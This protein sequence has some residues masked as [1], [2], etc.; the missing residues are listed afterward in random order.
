MGNEDLHTE[1]RRRALRGCNVE[2]SMTAIE[3]REERFVGDRSWNLER[4][5]KYPP[6]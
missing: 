2:G 5:L 6:T 3:S 1:R 4:T